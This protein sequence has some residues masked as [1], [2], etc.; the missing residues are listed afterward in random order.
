MFDNTN[1]DCCLNKADQTNKENKTRSEDNGEVEN[2]QGTG[3]GQ[4]SLCATNDPFIKN[5]KKSGPLNNR[6]V[7]RRVGGF[8]RAH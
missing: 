6:H 2:S 8:E 4:L 3:Y 7:K 1:I 5:G